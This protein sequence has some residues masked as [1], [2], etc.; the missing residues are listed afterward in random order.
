[1]IFS[2]IHFLHE[3]TFLAYDIKEASLY[4]YL[5][6]TRAKCLQLKCSNLVMNIGT[7]RT[8]YFDL[9]SCFI[10][11]ILQKR[12]KKKKKKYS[13]HFTN[14]YHLFQYFCI[15]TFRYS[16]RP[17]DIL[18]KELYNFLIFIFLSHER[19]QN[20]LSLVLARLG[21]KSVLIR[22]ALHVD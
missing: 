19:D 4:Q 6:W 21:N 7:Y 16:P 20:N 5:T 13:I 2:T 17:C 11:F 12:K 22:N 1:M 15:Y 9:K 8:K 3:A 10:L 18:Y 14:Q